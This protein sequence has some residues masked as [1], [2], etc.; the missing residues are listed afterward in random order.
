MHIY[1]LEGDVYVC[2]EDKREWIVNSELENNENLQ[3]AMNLKRI[4]HR[5]NWR[6]EWGKDVNTVLVCGI[7]KKSNEKEKFKNLKR[8]ELCQLQTVE[9][10]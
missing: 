6:E 2:L 1:T 3:N 8:Y 10:S 5:R 7:F 4:G 9:G